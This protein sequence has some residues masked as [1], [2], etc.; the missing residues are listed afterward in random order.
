MLKGLERFFGIIEQLQ[1]HKVS[2]A[3]DFLNLYIELVIREVDTC[4]PNYFADIYKEV[5]VFHLN[6]PNSF[7]HILFPL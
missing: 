5:P 6:K 4:N 1:M 3:T 2:Y 7:G